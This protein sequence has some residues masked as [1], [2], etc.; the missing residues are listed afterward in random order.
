MAD[1][2]DTHKFSMNH[3]KQLSEDKKCGCFYCMKIF[4][5]KEIKDWIDDSGG[6]KV[7][8]KQKNMKF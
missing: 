7:E 1:Y 5:P 4:N 2:I 8:W 3:K 6:T